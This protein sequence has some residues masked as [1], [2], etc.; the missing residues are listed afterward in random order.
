MKD[1]ERSHFEMKPSVDDLNSEII[2]RKNQTKTD[3]NDSNNQA[4][5][6]TR[7]EK[8]RFFMRNN[9][10]PKKT[11]NRKIGENKSEIET[12]KKDQ[13]QNDKKE[14]DKNY[15]CQPNKINSNQETKK[16]E[17]CNVSLGTKKSP[18]RK[19]S[20]SDFRVV[21]MFHK[22]LVEFANSFT[23]E[24]SFEDR[25]LSQ[26]FV[27]SKVNSTNESKSERENSLMKDSFDAN[28]IKSKVIVLENKKS[29][30]S[31]NHIEENSDKLQKKTLESKSEKEERIESIENQSKLKINTRET[32]QNQNK[33][34]QIHKKQNSI[35]MEFEEQ[36]KSKRREN[37]NKKS[38]KEERGSNSESSHASDEYLC[39]AFDVNK[40]CVYKRKL[41]RNIDTKQFCEIEQNTKDKMKIEEEKTLSLLN[42]ESEDINQSNQSQKIK[43]SKLKF[44]N[45]VFFL[46]QKVTE[47]SP[48]TF[49]DKQFKNLEPSAKLVKEIS[50]YSTVD[51]KQNQ[52]NERTHVGNHGN[53][54]HQLV[55][56][57][58]N[59][60][61]SVDQMYTNNHRRINI[62]NS[63][64]E[65]RFGNNKETSQRVILNYPD[66]K[67]G[68][69]DKIPKRT[70]IRKCQPVENVN[71]YR[72]D[73][74]NIPENRTTLMIKNI[75]N[76]YDKYMMME[77]IDADFKDTYDFSP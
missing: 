32:C 17:I 29:V 33:S 71:D 39:K 21:E 40:N 65:D 67:T 4:I 50:M 66:A 13:A 73:V 64:S 2:E 63:D 53:S 45:H 35:A 69:T 44:N 74:N 24:Q 11:N 36:K 28:N 54:E 22:P 41:V 23:N 15:E 58:Y 72:V 31:V 7:I 16:V 1:S 42:D 25:R 61:L 6:S 37:K 20:L 30:I 34:F 75:P 48:K 12:K 51:S 57:G 77:L 10:L 76:R 43:K 14:E 19:P 18:K 59:H 38:K 27:L 8:D 62:E 3:I 55:Y 68:V 52:N 60:A 49:L 47:I 5:E 70:Q 9:F 56:L 46:N 26:N